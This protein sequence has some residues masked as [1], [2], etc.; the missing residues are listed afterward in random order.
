MRLRGWI[1]FFVL[2]LA[3]GALAVAAVGAQDGVLA[4]PAALVGE[5]PA[6]A[7]P[8]SSVAAPVVEA[9]VPSVATATAPVT[10]PVA[11]V[12]DTVT[13]APATATETV[14]ESV[15]PSGAAVVGTVV[16]TGSAA[17]ATV[18]EA[19]G[20]AAPQ[21]GSP[22]LDVTEAVGEVTAVGSSV[23]SDLEGA[24][25]GVVS[26]GGTSQGGAGAGSVASGSVSP[27][28]SGAAARTQPADSPGQHERGHEQGRSQSPST[29]QAETPGVSGGFPA[30]ALVPGG[31]TP[32]ATSATSSDLDA[33]LA[34]QSLCWMIMS[35]DPAGLPILAALAF[36]SGDPAGAQTLATAAAADSE[37]IVA[38]AVEE[39]PLP[40]GDGHEWRFPGGLIGV[41]ASAGALLFGVLGMGAL[42]WAIAGLPRRAYAGIRISPENAVALRMTLAVAGLILLVCSLVFQFTG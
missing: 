42:C 35:G 19:A 41:D 5:L 6:N 1:L 27:S 4:E 9:A 34:W 11:A 37:T 38:A 30:G 13:E 26:A 24:I 36:R 31:G 10:E 16:S 20:Q 28:S 40:V 3:C 2:S 22:P 8:V 7:A 12:V 29:E 21:V 33:L 15:V 32:A 39:Q 14:E 17:V 23:G 25:P 18:N